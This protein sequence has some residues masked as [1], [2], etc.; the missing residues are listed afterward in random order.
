MTAT[1]LA[2]KMWYRFVSI[3]TLHR[4]AV[5]SVQ[6]T[7][8]ALIGNSSSLLKSLSCFTEIAAAD[9]SRRG[10]VTVFNGATRYLSQTNEQ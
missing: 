9:N 2:T 7:D 3:L 6:K 5:L 10:I 8:F 4:T 1:R